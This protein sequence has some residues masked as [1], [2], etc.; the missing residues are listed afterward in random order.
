MSLHFFSTAIQPRDLIASSRW[1]IL[2]A[3]RQRILTLEWELHDVPITRLRYASR[4]FGRVRRSAHGFRTT[5]LAQ[6]RKWIKTLETPQRIA[7]LK[8]DETLARLRLKP[9]DVVADIGAGSGIFE[10][11]LAQAVSPGGRV[12]AVDI[13]QDLVDHITQRAGELHLAN[14]QGVLGKFTDPALPV[15]NIDLA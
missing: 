5:R 10:A 13:Q 4:G 12:Y 7:S 11:P 15:R 8:I 14:V 9:G 3:S 2:P 1:R 6:R